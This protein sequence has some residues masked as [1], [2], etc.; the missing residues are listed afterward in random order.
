[1]PLF[2]GMTPFMV[3]YGAA[4]PAI[5]PFLLPYFETAR[6]PLELFITFVGTAPL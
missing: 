2:A 1:M 4:D 6:G 5:V 3:I